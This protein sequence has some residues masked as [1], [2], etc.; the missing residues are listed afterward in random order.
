MLQLSFAKPKV[1]WTWQ[2]QILTLKNH[3]FIHLPLP[4]F[5]LF[6]NSAPISISQPRS[7]SIPISI[8]ISI[9][10][11]T[12]LFNNSQSSDD[13]W[14][15]GI[16][17]ITGNAVHYCLPLWYILSRRSLYWNT[18]FGELAPSCSPPW[19]SLSSEPGMIHSQCQ[20][21]PSSLWFVPFCILN[22]HTSAA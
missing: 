6:P 8:S 7:V 13:I 15:G 9:S 1:F 21:T 10:I 12:C 3:D 14:L 16:S 17:L 20:Y 2:N 18:W 4:S 22:I 5:Q 19:G 11:S